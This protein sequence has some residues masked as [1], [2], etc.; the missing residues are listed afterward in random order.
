MALLLQKLGFAVAHYAALVVFVVACWA[1]GRLLL[2]RLAPPA[3]RDRW[4]EAAMATA[5]GIALFIVAFQ[6]LAVGGVL[7][8][9][10]VLV[11]VGAGVLAGALQWRSWRAQPH[12]SAAPLTG[13]DRFALAALACVALPT[14]TAPL[15][16]P[17]AFDEIMYHLPWSRQVA[18]SGRLGVYEWLR[19]PWFPYNYD[20]LYAAALQVYDDVFTHL[21][22]ALAGWLS[23]LMIYRLG[24]RHVNRLVACLGAIIWLALGDYPNSYIDMGVALLVLSAFVALWWWHECDAPDRGVRWLAL[25]AFF[26]G[27]AAGSKYQALI[28]LPLVAVFVGWRERRPQVW[29]L[30]LLCFLL[31][32]VYWY[33]RNAVMTGDPFNPIGA[34]LFGFTNWNAADYAQQIIDVQQHHASLPNV[35]L[36]PVLLAPFSL[37]WKRSVAVRA[38][39]WFCAWALLVWVVTSRYPR[40]LLP[41]YPLIALMAAVGW[42]QLFLWTGQAWR[43]PL[44]PALPRVAGRVAIVALVLVSASH[45]LRNA[46]MIAPTPET[47]EAFFQQCIPGYAVLSHLRTHPEPGRLYQVALNDSLYFAPNPVW[48]DIFGPWRY[49]DFV[50]LPADQMAR[51]LRDQQFSRIV[52]QTALAPYIHTNPDFDRHFQL[53]TE[54]DGVKA[55]RILPIAP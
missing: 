13:V 26:L 40:Y 8:R 9:G 35:M 25:A 31:P 53:I 3:W 51:K 5:L 30:A 42:H 36:W 52:I 20:L 24:L 1:F 55:Y 47:R 22:H 12:A 50:Y 29:G 37:A 17:V 21:L 7:G 49:S 43:W 33:A 11:L 28:F 48:G 4:L 19:Y 54:K 45:T 41:S 34:R 32:C 16:P 46:R 15:A 18:E 2:A 39:V 10:V 23:V 14:L 27:V 6:A 38:A 44:P